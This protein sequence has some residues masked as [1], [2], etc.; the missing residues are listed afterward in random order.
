MATPVD[1]V[2]EVLAYKERISRELDT[3]RP[4]PRANP[5]LGPYAVPD[6]L[7]D[8]A[9]PKSGDTQRLSRRAMHVA[10]SDD[11]YSGRR[12]ITAGSISS[13]ASQATTTSRSSVVQEKLR[14]LEQQIISEREGRKEIEDKIAAIERLLQQLIQ[15]NASPASSGINR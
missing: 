4:R 9:P 1:Y 13:T 14:N 10:S 12:P 3:I 15:K 11:F 5:P 2:P 7:P 8:E 6:R